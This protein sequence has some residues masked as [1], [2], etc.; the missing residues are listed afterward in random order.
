M[1][2]HPGLK[3]PAPQPMGS[4][5]SPHL[6]VSA[7]LARVLRLSGVQRDPVRPRFVL[8][9]GVYRHV[10]DREGSAPDRGRRRRDAHPGAH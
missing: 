5:Q 9:I 4:R 10:E 6:L 8:A 3:F 1:A 7:Q 2:R